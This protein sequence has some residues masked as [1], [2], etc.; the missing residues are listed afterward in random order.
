MVESEIL[1]HASCATKN[2]KRFNLFY[3]WSAS[4]SDTR[5]PVFSIGQDL[6]YVLVC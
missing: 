6:S 5:S 1:A 3:I 2:Y 4:I